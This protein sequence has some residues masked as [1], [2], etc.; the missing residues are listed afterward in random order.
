MENIQIHQFNLINIIKGTFLLKAVSNILSSKKNYIDQDNLIL[1]FFEKYTLNPSPQNNKIY[2]GL[3]KESIEL[4]F[5]EE[6]KDIKNLQLINETNNITIDSINCVHSND[7]KTLNCSF[8]EISNEK[9]GIYNIYYTGLCGDSVKIDNSNVEII[10][11]NI[12]TSIDPP[13]LK[14]NES[15]TRNVTLIYKENFTNDFNLINIR[16]FYNK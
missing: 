7:F 16:K 15:A 12:L 6:I 1:S 14:I 2:T 10:F 9:K 11:T 4:K 13:I 3:E 5:N 8:P